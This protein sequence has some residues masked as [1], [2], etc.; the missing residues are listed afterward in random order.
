MVVMLTPFFYV[1]LLLLSFAFVFA[2]LAGLYDAR[3][4]YLSLCWAPPTLYVIVL[5]LL[6]FGRI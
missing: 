5:V 3:R 6:L 2:V 4:A 1:L